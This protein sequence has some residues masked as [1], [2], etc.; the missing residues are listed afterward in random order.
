MQLEREFLE[1]GHLGASLELKMQ[2][3]QI[4]S[5]KELSTDRDIVGKYVRVTGNIVMLDF[6]KRLCQI[7]HGG[8]WLW[9]KIERID[10]LNVVLR[11]SSLVQFIGEVRSGDDPRFPAAEYGKVNY[12]LHA[13]V[14]R[15]VDGLDMSLYEQALSS[16]RDFFRSTA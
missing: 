1:V 7:E 6:D 13:K 15:V 10:T 2:S 16:R 5:L 12:F 9:V 14:A 11:E 3:G 8:V 4:V